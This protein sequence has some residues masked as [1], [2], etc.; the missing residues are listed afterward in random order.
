[1]TKVLEDVPNPNGPNFALPYFRRW[2]YITTDENGQFVC[3][4]GAD[5]DCCAQAHAMAEQRTQQ[6]PY[7]EAI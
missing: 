5:T 4:S 1:M 7:N 2:T 3:A 6:R